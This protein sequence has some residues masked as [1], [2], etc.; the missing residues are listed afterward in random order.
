MCSGKPLLMTL[1]TTCG[2][3]SAMLV[4][5]F[6]LLEMQELTEMNRVKCRATMENRHKKILKAVYNF[7]STLK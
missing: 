3:G 2:V 5:Y 6:S 7:P 1:S 4:G